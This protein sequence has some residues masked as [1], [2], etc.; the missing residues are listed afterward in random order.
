M[1]WLSYI[2]QNPSTRALPSTLSI[3]IPSCQRSPGLT[4]KPSTVKQE[5]LNI[6]CNKRVSQL[7][8]PPSNIELHNHPRLPASFPHLCV[9]NS[10]VMQ[11]VQHTLRGE[12]N[13]LHYFEYLIAKFP[14]IIDPVQDIHWP[15]L[16][17]AL[18]WFKTAKGRILSIFIHKWLLLN[19]CHQTSNAMQVQIW[20]SCRQTTETVDHFF[21]CHHH[22][23]QQI[24]KDLHKQLYKHQIK[25]SVS[26]IFHNLLAASLYHGHGEP[27][28][29]TFHHATNE[30]LQLHQQ[31]EQLGW[32]QLYYGRM[33]PSWIAG[34]QAYHPQLN[35]MTYYTQCVTFIWKAILQIW[36]LWNQHQHPSSYTGGSQPIRSRGPLHLSRSS[37]RPH[38]TGHDSQ[39]HTRADTQSHHASSSAVDNQ[40]QKSH[41]STPQ[42]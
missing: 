28:H 13:K 2:C 24:W 20:P 35:V 14:G 31:Q 36:K 21:A 8:P 37:T 11:K 10:V 17:L 22:D 1:W 29:I 30:I 5:Q 3:Q 39:H 18:K 26:N 16:Q 12:A 15:T 4:E 27:T 6:D 7:P 41:Q 19:D 9:G 38:P 32:W 23:H 40:Q 34:L 25:N 42:S 33:S